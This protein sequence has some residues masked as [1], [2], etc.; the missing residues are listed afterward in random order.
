MAKIYLLQVGDYF[1]I[2]YTKNSVEKRVKQLQTGSPDKITICEVFETKHGM[3][4]ERTLH[5][6]F[7]HKRT[8]GEFFY[9]DV[10]DKIN[11]V[12]IC[13]KIEKG[14]DAIQNS[15]FDII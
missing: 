15:F 7:S 1:K 6:I 10:K 9:L 4:V 11:F 3:K 8:N 12:Q 14:L 13:G 2:G 5:S